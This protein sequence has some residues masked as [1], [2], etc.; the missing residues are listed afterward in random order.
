MRSF[1]HFI[2]TNKIIFFLFLLYFFP[3]SNSL[4]L[5]LAIVISIKIL[6]QNLI[7]YPENPILLRYPLTIHVANYIILHL[8]QILSQYGQLEGWLKNCSFFI[9]NTFTRPLEDARIYV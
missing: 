8:V 4:T 5:A 7:P 9:S 3:L 1:H 2:G 6:D